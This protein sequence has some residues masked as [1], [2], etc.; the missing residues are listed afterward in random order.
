MPIGAL[1]ICGLIAS[2]S[3]SVDPVAVHMRA[4]VYEPEHDEV[5]A[6]NAV[7]DYYPNR[8]SPREVVYHHLSGGT[9]DVECGDDECTQGSFKIIDS[10]L[11]P[12]GAYEFIVTSDP[13]IYMVR[14]AEGARIL[15]YLAKNDRTGQMLYVSDLKQAQTVDHQGDAS[16][17]AGKIALGA[18]LVAA[19]A[20][21]V[22]VAAA[23]DA[24]A[25]Q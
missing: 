25:S 18:L 14:D 24:P 3:Q 22:V 5:V 20:A 23:A 4:N 11:M 19:L 6:E 8:Q 9:I 13:H 12:D 1:V 15:G 2:C 17:T 16:R 10:K 21:L 7:T